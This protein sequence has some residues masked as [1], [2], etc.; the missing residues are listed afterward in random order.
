M[1]VH[2]NANHIYNLGNKIETIGID[3]KISEHPLI[4]FKK[5]INISL[6]DDIENKIILDN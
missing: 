3:H 6:K 5:R 2:S 1:E 4:I